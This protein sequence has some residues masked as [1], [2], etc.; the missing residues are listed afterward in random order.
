[1]GAVSVLDLTVVDHFYGRVKTKVKNIA[2]KLYLDA[3]F[4]YSFIE[5]KTEP[6]VVK[7]VN[8]SKPVVDRG[9]VGLFSL[10]KKLYGKNNYDELITLSEKSCRCEDTSSESCRCESEVENKDLVAN[11]IRN[12]SVDANVEP[13]VAWGE[14]GDSD[15]GSDDGS[16]DGSDGSDDGSDES[17]DSGNESDDVMQD[18]DGSGLE[19]DHEYAQMLRDEDP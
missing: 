11:L 1:M 16:E 2:T 17:D 10:Y 19:D 18:Y 6:Y 14:E 4:V 5:M 3:V 7:A 9:Y 13:L 15:N 12:L 8:Y